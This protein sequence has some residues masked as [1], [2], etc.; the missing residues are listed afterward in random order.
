MNFANGPHITTKIFSAV[1]EVI[2]NYF[3]LNM[4]N[5]FSLYSVMKYNFHT[6]HND[7]AMLSC[8]EKSKDNR[9]SAPLVL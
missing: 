5:Y 3:I 1:K 6:V 2:I 4:A 9:L 8:L 7:T